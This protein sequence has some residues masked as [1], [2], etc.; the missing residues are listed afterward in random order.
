LFCCGQNL[1]RDWTAQAELDQLTSP[2]TENG[3][4]WN[5][6]FHF[7]LSLAVGG[8]HFDG[9]GG[10]DDE[11]A[12]LGWADPT[13]EID[14]VRVW[15]G[16]AELD[17][18]PYKVINAT[19]LLAVTGASGGKR[20]NKAGTLV[21]VAT[22]LLFGGAWTV[23]AF[24]RAWMR[25]KQLEYR[26]LLEADVDAEDAGGNSV[27]LA[28]VSARQY[29]AGAASGQSP[30]ADSGGRDGPHNGAAWDTGL[31]DSAMDGA[32]AAGLDRHREVPAGG[33][34]HRPVPLTMSAQGVADQES[35][36]HSPLERTP[37]RGRFSV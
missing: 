24:V 6:R 7:V 32:V 22:A 13:M 27:Q 1:Q 5:Q 37:L 20:V 36:E 21:L 2:Y 18:V 17:E 9:F 15:E 4:P 12:G 35:P 11:T 19:R 28:V 29:N 8:T 10:L 16:E 23:W 34:A 31:G 25:T 14:Y 30:S 3:E 26:G 33:G